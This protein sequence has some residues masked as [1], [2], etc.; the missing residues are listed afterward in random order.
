MAE[1]PA[2]VKPRLRGVSHLSMFPVAVVLAIPLLFIGRTDEAR[3]AVVFGTGV[4]AMFG[5]SGL[6]HV[7]AVSLRARS[8]RPLGSITRPCTA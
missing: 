1:L 2:L 7:V 5:V 4:A 3:L 8:W 6:Y